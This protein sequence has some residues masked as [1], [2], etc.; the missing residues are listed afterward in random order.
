MKG[1]ISNRKIFMVVFAV[2]F[3]GL[4]T[5]TTEAFIVT[6]QFGGT[7]V[8]GD[9][10]GNEFNNAQLLISITGD[11]A[12]VRT[13]T[14]GHIIPGQSLAES[15]GVG[16]TG[17]ISLTGGLQTINYQGSF[18][19]NLY[20]FSDGA[21]L[22]GFGS[23]GPNPGPPFALTDLLSISVGALLGYDLR[24]TY[25]QV[26]AGSLGSLNSIFPY[27]AGGTDFGELAIDYI[28][29]SSF[30]AVPVP[31]PVLL[32]ASGLIG[33]FGIRRGFRK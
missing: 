33:L 5:A 14:L 15:T 19:S 25:P 7:G 22:V 4:M 28:T 17:T 13:D 18:T 3:F 20:V 12:N 10:D 1:L 16:L 31:A 30:Q 24:S 2:V 29:E 6:Y 26:F 32:L 23:I 27:L 11:T 21:G 9:V 8:F